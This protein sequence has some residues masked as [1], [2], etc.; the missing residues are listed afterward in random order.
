MRTVTYDF[1]VHSC[2]SPCGDDTMTPSSAAGMLMLA[3]VQAAA[4][5]DHNSV[6]N[7]PVFF[8]ACEQYGVL[9]IGGM[10][11]TT[12]EEIHVVCLFQT[13]EKTMAFGEAVEQH[14]IRIKNKPAFFGNQNI[15][16]MDDCVI[17]VENDLLPNATDLS[18]EQAFDLT[19]KLGGVCYPAHV[20]R[21]SNGILA[22]LGDLPQCPAFRFAEYADISSIEKLQREYP[23][24]Q[25]LV[26]LF[27]SDAH[28]LEDIPDA[29][30]S[31][32]LPDEGSLSEALFAFLKGECR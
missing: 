31:L 24:L 12:A 10:E 25:P 9:P 30:A 21:E 5:T 23:R 27:G 22:V 4:L 15:T 1:H 17:G 16:D 26:P 20:D 2:L 6:K 14:R 13:L 29:W 18:L 7:C 28:R 8:A 32:E 3:G 11:L 19:V